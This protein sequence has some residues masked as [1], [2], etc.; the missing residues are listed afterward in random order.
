MAES[1][2][3][4]PPFFQLLTTN[5]NLPTLS[6]CVH[7][8]TLFRFTLSLYSDPITSSVDVS[9][10]GRLRA[11]ATVWRGRVFHSV[12]VLIKEALAPY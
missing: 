6:D 8:V 10:H 7:F 11:L 5:L 1:D 12:L 9:G 4:W 2:H 3:L